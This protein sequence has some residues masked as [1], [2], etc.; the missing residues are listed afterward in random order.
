MEIL[1]SYFSNPWSFWLLP[2]LP[3]LATMVLAGGA[4]PAA[5]A[6]LGTWRR[7]WPW[8]AGAGDWAARVVRLRRAIL[9]GAGHRRAAVGTRLEPGRGQGRDLVVVLDLSRSMLAQDVLPSRVERA[10]AALRKLSYVFQHAAVTA[11]PW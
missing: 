9:P 6:R 7:C 3:A 2:L 5:A 8:P 11:W 10:K 1:L 4:A